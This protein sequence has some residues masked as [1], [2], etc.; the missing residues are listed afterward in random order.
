M[1]LESSGGS[2]DLCAASVAACCALASGVQ[3]VPVI[4]A[5]APM[6]ALRMMNDRRLRFDEIADSTTDAGDTASL[7]M[8]CSLA[9]KGELICLSDMLI[10]SFPLLGCGDP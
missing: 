4:T 7:L 1:E 3:T 6:T 10:S 8:S 2:T 5:A 9:S